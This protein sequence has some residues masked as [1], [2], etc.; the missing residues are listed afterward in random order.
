M[1][2]HRWGWALMNGETTARERGT[3]EIESVDELKA[4]LSRSL[5]EPAPRE[6]QERASRKGAAHFASP[7]DAAMPASTPAGIAL[8]VA[9]AEHDPCDFRLAVRYEEETPRVRQLV[10]FINDRAR[11]ETD[12]RKTGPIQAAA[13]QRR[14][15][16]P[17]AIGSS[18]MVEDVNDA[19]TI[20]AFVVPKDTR[21]IHVLSNAHVLTNYGL[22]ELG[23][24]IVQPGGHDGGTVADRIGALADWSPIDLR[25]NMENSVDAAI[26]RLDT[27]IDAVP[28]KVHPV[29]QI[30]AVSDARARF[31]AGERIQVQ[32][33]GRTTEHTVGQL[34]AVDVEVR[35]RYRNQQAIFRHQLEV[36]PSETKFAWLGDSGSL[37]MDSDGPPAPIGLLFAVGAYGFGYAN[38]IDRVTN[39][40]GINLVS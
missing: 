2:L 38:P 5:E 15:H 6:T 14:R 29:G 33:V 19:G 37:L 36:A 28:G 39:A 12:V 30:G 9:Q 25:P 21:D 1:R 31:R 34:I 18:V 13:W 10:A 23:A 24:G 26:A 7:E 32:K 3:V 17:C 20:G 11:G 4:V 8:G 22:A 40:L 35:P 27:G 16:R